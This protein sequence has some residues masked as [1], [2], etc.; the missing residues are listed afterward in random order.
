MLKKSEAKVVEQAN[1]ERAAVRP[2]VAGQPYEGAATIE[3]LETTDVED[4]Q[5]LADAIVALVGT[6]AYDDM[7]WN[8]VDHAFRRASSLVKQNW[9]A[10]GTVKAAA[11]DP[12]RAAPAKAR[13]WRP[14]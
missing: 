1:V 5:T 14:T 12:A 13:E 6:A 3:L 2:Q 10:T 9:S 8:E 7:T 4:I 11:A